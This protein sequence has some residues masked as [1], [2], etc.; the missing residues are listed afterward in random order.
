MGGALAMSWW[1]WLL[2]VWLAFLAGFFL[3]ALWAG[4]ER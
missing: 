2:V 3:G 1:L 4:S